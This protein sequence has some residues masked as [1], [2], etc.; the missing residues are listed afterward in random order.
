MT[1]L[2]LLGTLLA[3]ALVDATSFGTLVIP[4]W[5]LLSTRRPL[6]GR[7]LLFL[8]VVA[9]LY[10]LIG[11][12][13]MLGAGILIEHF[14]S[15]LETTTAYV[16]Q[17]GVG[18]GLFLLSFVI[19]P[20]EAG[21]RRRAARVRARA[22]ARGEDPDAPSGP[23]GRWR[24]RITG[25]PAALVGVAVA[26]VGIELATMLPYLGAIGLMRAHAPS[27]PAALG[28]LAGYCVVMVLPALVL[29]GFRLIGLPWVDR[30]LRRVEVWSERSGASTIAWILGVLGVIL[31]LQGIGVLRDRGFLG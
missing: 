25:S 29:L 18:I 9:G 31:T 1:S 14:S 5:L 23:R 13:V 11:V 8:G 17:V 10:F 3:L 19:E 22:E 28:L 24:E 2:V 4:V 27:V 20:T 26:A 12:A 6:T 16:I 21:K 30:V 15:S 7:I